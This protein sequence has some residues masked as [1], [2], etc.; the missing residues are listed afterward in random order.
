M[1]TIHHQAIHDPFQQFWETTAN[2]YSDSFQYMHAYLKNEI[3]S[4]SQEMWV[5]FYAWDLYQEPPREIALG[6]NGRVGEQLRKSIVRNVNFHHNWLLVSAYESLERFLK[7]IYAGIGLN[8]H[9]LWRPCDL[10][11]IN[12]S[13]M[14]LT[15]IKAQ[16][17]QTIGRHGATDIVNV[18]RN[19]F[20]LND[21]TR[22]QNH[23]SLAYC[24]L[25]FWF[26]AAELLRHAI[27]HSE[28]CI[29][30]TEQNIFCSV[31]TQMA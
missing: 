19:E 9:S 3:P 1:S 2:I 10:Q 25:R 20:Q 17:R 22:N 26:G 13:N 14:D 18:L 27:V 16:V 31:S 15:S 24:S 7:D 21:G 5:R 8:D 11:G 28:G 12:L 23:H 29:Y 4:P 6:D 30:D